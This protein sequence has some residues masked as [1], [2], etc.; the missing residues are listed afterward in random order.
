MAREK[1]TRP[2]HRGKPW[3]TYLIVWLM[4]L[5]T[6]FFLGGVVPYGLFF[7]LTA[8][9]LLSLAYSFWASR[10]VAAAQELDRAVVQKGES[11]IF[12]LL[13]R[14]TSALAPCPLLE[15]GVSDYETAMTG[16]PKKMAVS[17][18]PG[19]QLGGKFTLLFPYRGAWPVG[20]QTLFLR[21]LFGIARFP[22]KKPDM[23]RVVVCPRVLPLKRCVLSGALGPPAQRRYSFLEEPHAMSDTR[24]YQMG[25]PLKR[26]HWKLSAQKGELISKVYEHE[27]EQE[28]LLVL[29]TNLPGAP[30]R[31]AF[32]ADQLAEAVLAVLDFCLRNGWAVR[33]VHRQGQ[34]YYW[35]EQRDRSGFDRLY[36]HLSEMPFE[37][38]E[39]LARDMSRG[40]SGARPSGGM[41]LFTAALDE[42]LLRA[43]AIWNQP[44][45][46]AEVVYIRPDE[47][48]YTPPSREESDVS[49]YWMPSGENIRSLLEG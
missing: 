47:G 6:V 15:A 37:P 1:K 14:N 49:V 30:E 34:E 48:V 42:E 22:V 41:V 12:R 25:D 43:A 39:D 5:I 33:F 9:P 45:R 35:G 4:G 7:L 8:A 13:L 36:L 32:L 3:R 44:A 27:S 20:A 10:R 29:D 19:Q 46:P 17:L 40:F 38:A 11:V 21:D 24:P 28:V 18:L 16:Q 26:L 31:A 23:L 2:R